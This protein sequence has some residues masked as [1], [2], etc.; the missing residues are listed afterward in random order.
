MKPSE[1]KVA[2]VEWPA[3]RYAKAVLLADQAQ[4]DA[5]CEAS[6][7]KLD[8]PLGRAR[9]GKSVL[10]RLGAGSIWEDRRGDLDVRQA[11]ADE[12]RKALRYYARRDGL[13]SHGRNPELAELDAWSSYAAL[14][15]ALSGDTEGPVPERR[16]IASAARQCEWLM[17]SSPWHTRMAAFWDLGIAA[18]WPGRDTIA[19]LAATDSD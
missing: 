7:F 12:V 4:D 10:L 8:R 15:G 18:L 9:F 17:F 5:I 6:L 14:S 19:I 3:A 16:E 13:L 11:D 1:F 2:E